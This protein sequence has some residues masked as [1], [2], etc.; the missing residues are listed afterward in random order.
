MFIAFLVIWC[1]VW[2][3]NIFPKNY[4]IKEFR[5][6]TSH[7]LK[8]VTQ[9]ALWP[10]FKNIFELLNQYT[11]FHNPCLKSFPCRNNGFQ[12]Y[13]SHVYPWNTNH[14]KPISKM[15]NIAGILELPIPKP[16]QYS[17]IFLL[18]AYPLIFCATSE[19]ERVRLLLLVPPGTAVVQPSGVDVVVV[20]F[21][22]AGENRGWCGTE[23]TASTT[24][25]SDLNCG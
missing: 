10:F 23:G 5:F 1:V 21:D 12:I 14:A 15:N 22:V 8:F 16:P 18:I 7:P 19:K 4:N 13:C 24:R 2:L 9:W 6:F 3:L 25:N 20:R 11:G 17:D